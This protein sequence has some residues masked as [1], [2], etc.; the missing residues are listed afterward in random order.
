MEKAR[1]FFAIKKLFFVLDIPCWHGIYVA[2]S[3]SA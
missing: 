3:V 1:D 2:Y